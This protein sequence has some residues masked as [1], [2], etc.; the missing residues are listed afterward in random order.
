MEPDIIHILEM[1]AAVIATIIAVW[2]NRQKSQVMTENEALVEDLNDAAVDYV[3]VVADRAQVVS[4]FDPQ[5]DRVTEPPAN[6]PGRS[7]KMSDGTK[8]WVICGHTPDEQSSLLNQ[9]TDAEKER[10]VQYIIS[11]PGCY[12]EIEYGLLKGGGKGG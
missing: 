6:I 7:W 1:I 2:Q 4:F 11:V 3:N 12:Y 5:N 8:Q 10:K 9:I